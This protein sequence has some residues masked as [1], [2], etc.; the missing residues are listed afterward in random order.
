MKWHTLE[1][2]M[3]RTLVKILA[4]TIAATLV[5][6]LAG[7]IVFLLIEDRYVQPANYSERKVDDIEALVGEKGAAL[8]NASTAPLLDEAVSDSD[9]KYQVVDAN[10]RTLYGTYQPENVTLNRQVLLNEINRAND[11]DG[12]Y[13]HTVPIFDDKSTLIGAVRC[14]YELA[15]RFE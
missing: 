1:S 9:L 13:V 4:A 12:H 11:E 7:G 8:L 15:V 6:Y 2:G 10:G 14:A 3:R 5:T